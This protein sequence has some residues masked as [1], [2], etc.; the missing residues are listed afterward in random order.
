MKEENEFSQERNFYHKEN[1]Y[2][3]MISSCVSQ[4]HDLFR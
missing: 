4:A 2:D 3:E 1:S